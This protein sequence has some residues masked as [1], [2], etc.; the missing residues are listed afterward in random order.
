MEISIDQ[1]KP[2]AVARVAGALGAQDSEAFVEQIHPLVAQR[3]SKLIIGL[4]QVPSISSS[5]LSALVSIATRAR[6]AE[7]RVI[8]VG[9]TSFVKG[10][11]DVTQLDDWF[12]ICDDYAEAERR[13]A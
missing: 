1:S 2:Y 12:E 13:L 5:G 3:G 10:I 4:D 11:L 7:G 8:L 6:L 9:P